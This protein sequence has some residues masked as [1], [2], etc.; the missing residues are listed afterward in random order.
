MKNLVAILVIC[1]GFVGATMAQ[2][3]VELKNAGNTALREKNYSV[4]L[5]NFEQ[6]LAAWGEQDTD[7]AMIYNAGYCAYKTKDFT[8]AVKYFGQAIDASYKAETAFLYKANSL[9]KMKDT[10]GYVST[11]EAGLVKYPNSKK[12]KSMIS[13][14]YLKKGN[15]HYK[16]AAG[17]LK[18][19]ANN[20]A[21]GKYTTNDDAYKA[22]VVKAKGEFKAAMPF[23]EKALEYTPNDSTA[24]ALKAGIEKNL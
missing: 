12:I 1:F 2:D 22:E 3:A 4:A 6:S 18:A 17:I 11:L 19:A 14:F 23:I 13:K 8:K 9:Y 5:T 7:W 15:A 10:E 24:Q 16:S 21:G 20:V